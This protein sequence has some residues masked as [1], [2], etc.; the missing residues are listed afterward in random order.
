MTSC[1]TASR[2]RAG[3]PP[4][5]FPLSLQFSIRSGGGCLHAVGGRQSVRSPQTQESRNFCESAQSEADDSAVLAASI[6]RS[7]A[8]FRVERAAVGCVL[9][10]T[11]GPTRYRLARSTSYSSL[12]ESSTGLLRM[13][14]PRDCATIGAS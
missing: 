4:N 6:R 7:L 9:L 1:G 5:S 12:S 13:L 3:S 2:V 10:T 11:G 8:A 14:P